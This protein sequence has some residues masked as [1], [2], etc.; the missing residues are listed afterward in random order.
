MSLRQDGAYSFAG[1]AALR[2]A[3][4]TKAIA[5]IAA[6]DDELMLSDQYQ[7]AVGPSVPVRVIPGV[8]HMAVL[9]APDAVAAIAGD[10]ANYPPAR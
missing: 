2:Y 6:G 10:V 5:L 8:N 9:S 3:G 7:S 1:P 4:R